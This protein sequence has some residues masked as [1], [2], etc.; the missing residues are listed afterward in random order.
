MAE[1]FGNMKKEDSPC[2]DI[3]D[4]E[5]EVFRILLHFIY[6]DT[7]PE[8]DGEEEED[9]KMMA[10]HLLTAADRYGL[11]RLKLICEEKVR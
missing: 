5:A 3:K 7:L 11:E 10:Q 1:L 4:M 2:V 6:T 9:A 8:Q